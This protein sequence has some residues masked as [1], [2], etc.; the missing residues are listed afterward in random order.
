[1][2]NFA[3]FWKSEM[4]L[5]AH[6]D[7]SIRQ[8]FVIAKSFFKCKWKFADHTRVISGCFLPRCR[9]VNKL[10]NAFTGLPGQVF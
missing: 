8:Y 1:M 7:G 10:L 6:V 3:A 9:E 5:D 4:S 2:S